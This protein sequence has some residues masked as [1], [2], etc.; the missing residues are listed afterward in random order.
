MINYIVFYYR[1]QSWINIWTIPALVFLHKF[2]VVSFASLIF[3]ELILQ[4][5][6]VIWDNRVIH[7]IWDLWS[8][9]LKKS[10]K[11]DIL[12]SK[13]LR[14]LLPEVFI[15][16]CIV[17]TS[18]PANNYPHQYFFNILNSSFHEKGL[19]SRIV[20]EKWINK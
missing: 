6:N 16:K 11:T 17:E 9:F 19:F 7:H 20:W 1:G 3:N 8:L 2:A 12:L 18:N 10:T 14:W 15:N 5:W 13:R 4:Q